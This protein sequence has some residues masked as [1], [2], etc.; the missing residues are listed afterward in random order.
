MQPAD[1]IL[2]PGMP[3]F[4]KDLSG[5]DYDVTEAK[6]LIKVS[7]YGDV[8]KLPPITITT[9]GW[10]GLISQGLEAIISEWRN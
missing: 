1:G 3:G 5:L 7:K 4:N 9:M 10:G 6:E 8:S 2:P